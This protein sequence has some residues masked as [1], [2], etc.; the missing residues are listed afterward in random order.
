MKKNTSKTRNFLLCYT[1]IYQNTTMSL[2]FSVFLSLVFNLAEIFI[3]LQKLKLKGLQLRQFWKKII[4][5]EELF[6]LL[7]PNLLEHYNFSQFFGIS[8]TLLQRS[9]N[10]NFL[11]KTMTLKVHSSVNFGNKPLM[12]KNFFFTHKSTQIPNFPEFFGISCSSFQFSE[13]FDV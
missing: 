10:V 4:K 13:S 1:Q 8:Y 2:N 11:A 7:Y 12:K 6:A 9:Q 5:D 3:V